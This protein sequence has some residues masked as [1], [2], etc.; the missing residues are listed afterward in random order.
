MKTYTQEEARQLL[1]KFRQGFPSVAAWLDAQKM[2]PINGG[3]LH[4][5]T[6]LDLELDAFDELRRPE[7]VDLNFMERVFKAVDEETGR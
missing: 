4:P 6:L 7:P 2:K 5:R 1:D 3:F